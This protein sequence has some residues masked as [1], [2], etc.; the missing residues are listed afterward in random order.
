MAVAGALAFHKHSLFTAESSTFAL[1]IGMLGSHE[2]QLWKGFKITHS[3]CFYFLQ[4]EE[5]QRE[6]ERH[7]KDTNT[8]FPTK[9][10]SFT[11]LCRIIMHLQN[12]CQSVYPSVYKIL[13]SVKALAGGIKLHVV[14][15]LSFNTPP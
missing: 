1:L 12:V 4:L 14:T 11:I 13:V 2:W 3:G 10:R 6:G 8:Q 7:R 15:A 9:V 5:R